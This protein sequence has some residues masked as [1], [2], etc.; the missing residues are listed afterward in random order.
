MDCLFCKIVS[1]E[2]KCSKVW[3]DD[4]HLA[5]LTPYPNTKGSTVVIP[6]KHMDSYAFDLSDKN[7]SDLVLK[8]RIVGKLLDKKL[9]G[10]GR[11]AMVLEG[12]GVNHVHVKLFPLHKTQKYIKNWKP[13]KSTNNKYFEKYEGYISSH[14]GHKINYKKLEKIAEKIRDRNS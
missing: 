9:K 5:F 10:V 7:L 8:S 2:E 11:T 13:I 14:D 1:G 4:T 6:K 3:E 12:F